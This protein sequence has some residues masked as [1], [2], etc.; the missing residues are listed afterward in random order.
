MIILS[1][2]APVVKGASLQNGG[3]LTTGYPYLRRV[4]NAGHCVVCVAATDRS[5]KKPTMVDIVN[6]ARVSLA[7][8]IGDY[9][10]VSAGQR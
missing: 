5:R 1:M 10:P 3:L 9:Q 6:A 4:A 2:A 7:N 8:C